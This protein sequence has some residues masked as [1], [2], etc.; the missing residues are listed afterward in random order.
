VISTDPATLAA[1][2][3]GSATIETATRTGRAT[4]TGDIADIK[5]LVESVRIPQQ[6]RQS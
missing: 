5:W 6:A 4:V 3:A 1:L 2:F